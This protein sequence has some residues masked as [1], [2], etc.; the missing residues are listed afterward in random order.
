MRKFFVFMIGL[1]LCAPAQALDCDNVID[2]RYDEREDT[3]KFLCDTCM[4]ATGCQKLDCDGYN[5]SYQGDI[6]SDYGSEMEFLCTSYGWL[7]YE[8]SC[9]D[10]A[11]VR[12]L[13]DACSE[14]RTAQICSDNTIATS[15]GGGAIGTATQVRTGKLT[16]NTNNGA[17]QCGNLSGWTTSSRKCNAGYYLNGTQ[18][19]SCALATGNGAAVSPAGA[20]SITDCYLPAGTTVADAAGNYKMTGNCSYSN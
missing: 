9:L 3:D 10:G 17:C 2:V 8:S 1:I 4:G 19:V 12:G 18:C 5:V 20:T 14:T 13:G 6:I 16:T 15:C 11:N 7:Q